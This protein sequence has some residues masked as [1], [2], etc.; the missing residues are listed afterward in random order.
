MAAGVGPHGLMMVTRS[1]EPDAP[2]EAASIDT[3]EG[4]VEGSVSDT[5]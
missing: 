3:A 2:E 4:K 5:N 1:V